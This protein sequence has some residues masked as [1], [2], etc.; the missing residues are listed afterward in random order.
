MNLIALGTGIRALDGTTSSLAGVPDAAERA[1][2]F[3][4]LCGRVRGTFPCRRHLLESRRTDISP[5]NPNIPFGLGNLPAKPGNLIEPVGA[6]LI[7]AFPLPNLNVG[8]SNY[9]PYHNW[10]A[11]GSVYDTN[12]QG[13]T[14][15]AALVGDINYTHVFNPTTWMYLS[16]GYGHNWYPT[17]GAAAS[18]G[19]FDPAKVLGMPSYID[20]SGF[21]TAFDLALQYL[22]LHRLPAC[23]CRQCRPSFPRSAWT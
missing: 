8:S 12:T 20:T 6:K 15:H 16:L 9:D 3:S 7:Q 4:E 10:M 19:G 13:P 17:D 11:T 23:R 2:D 14:K 5:G 21:C 1:G 22:W 18:F